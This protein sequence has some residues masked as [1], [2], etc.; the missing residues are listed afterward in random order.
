M[1]VTTSTA[2]NPLVTTITTDADADVTVET[3][4]GSNQNVY[5]IEITNPNANEAVYVHVINAASGSTVSTQHQHQFY[6]PANTSCY[7]MF[8]TAYRTSTG[9][10]FY[11]STS[12]GGGAQAAS[13]TENV[14]VVIGHTAR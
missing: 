10:Q 3:A 5:A 14:T 7:Y 11:T 9:I 2:S 8:P 1:A 4:S 6:C 12:A 13:P